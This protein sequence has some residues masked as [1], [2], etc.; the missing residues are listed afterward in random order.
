MDVID[1][2]LEANRA[3]AARFQHGHLGAVPARGL[4]VVT[5]MDCRI[6][7]E[8]MLGLEIGDAHVLRNAGGIVTDDVLR[9]LVVSHHLLGTREVMIINHTGCGMMTFRDEDLSAR[10]RQTAGSAASLQFYAFMDIE[11]N[12]RRQVAAVRAHPWIPDSVIVRGFVYDVSNGR[13][14]EVDGP[15][16]VAG[17]F[18]DEAQWDAAARSLPRNAPCGRDVIED[19][20]VAS[21][22]R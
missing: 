19:R 7:V 22:S 15:A 16:G 9:S 1:R 11:E 13:L 2:G 3:Y 21:E 5:C 18:A 20:E 4:A 6:A 12:V 14:D 8:R 17:A 10:L